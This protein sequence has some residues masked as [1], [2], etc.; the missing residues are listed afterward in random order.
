MDVVI[1]FVGA[2][3]CWYAI[4]MVNAGRNVKTAKKQ[5]PEADSNVQANPRQP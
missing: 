1:S 2:F 3:F 5:E 4:Q